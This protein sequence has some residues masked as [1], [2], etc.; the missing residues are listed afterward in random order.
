LPPVQI[1]YYSDVLCI[2]AYISEIRIEMIEAKFGDDI[3]LEKK[4]CSVFGDSNRR[5]SDSWGDRGGFAGFNSHLS[6]VSKQFPHIKLHHDTWSK[7]RPASSTSP[8]LYLKAVEL[9]EKDHEPGKKKFER[10]LTSFREAFFCDGRDIARREVQDE[11]AESHGL[12]TTTISELIS[13]GD[14]FA[15]LASD[16]Q[17]ADRLQVRGSPSFVMNKGRQKLYGNVGFH[18]IEANIKELLRPPSKRE[19]SW[20]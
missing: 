14:A 20:C 2:W 9:A 1:S 6:D 17:D 4:F 3:I 12:N 15:N 5:I 11:L 8:H 18:L 16:Y 19:A 13:N 10:T 7:I